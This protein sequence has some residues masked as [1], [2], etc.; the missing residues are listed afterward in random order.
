VSQT[1]VRD[2]PILSANCASSA[3]SDPWPRQTRGAVLGGALVATADMRL[4]NEPNLPVENITPLGPD[5]DPVPLWYHWQR[6][7]SVNHGLC[8]RAGRLTKSTAELDFY[9]VSGLRPKT[10][11][12]VLK[13][14]GG[15]PFPWVRIPPPPQSTRSDPVFG[16]ANEDL[17]LGPHCGERPRP[18]LYHC[19][20]ARRRASDLL[21][22]QVERCKTARPVQAARVRPRRTAQCP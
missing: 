12:L 11:N 13:P 1:S 14:S 10:P 9:R 17:E 2:R 15:S 5:P 16:P 18:L 7:M 22:S 19:Q 3:R 4:A 6:Q 8:R 21:K 20:R